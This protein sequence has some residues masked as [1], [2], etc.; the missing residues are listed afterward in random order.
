MGSLTINSLHNHCWVRGWKK[1]KV[2]QHLPRLWAIKQGVVFYETRCIFSGVMTQNPQDLSPWARCNIYIPSW[3][4]GDFRG[5]GAGPSA[6][7]SAATG[8]A[9]CMSQGATFIASDKKDYVLPG[10]CLFVRS[11][12]CLSV[13][14]TVSKIAQKSNWR[15]LTRIFEGVRCLIKFWWWPGCRYIRVRV[16][17][18]L[19]L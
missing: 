19:G 10:D 15:V 6:P 9:S 8:L 12:V 3:P 17:I 4:S 16:R 2:G 1:L 11:S 7:C 13:W 18:R 5:G 14:L